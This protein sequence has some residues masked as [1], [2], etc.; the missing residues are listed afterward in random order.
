MDQSTAKEFLELAETVSLLG[1]WELNLKTNKLTWSDGVFRICGYQPNAFEVT[2]ESGLSIIHPEDRAFAIEKMT[3]AIEKG[4]PYEIVKRFIT[5][6][7][8]II[9]ILSKA[10]V[11]MDEN[12]NPDKLFGVF[13]DI[14][15]RVQLENEYKTALKELKSRNQF[16]ETIIEHLPI[17]IAVNKISTGEATIVNPS[18]SNIYGWNNEDFINIESFFKK[19]YPDESYRTK[20]TNRIYA[21]IQSGNPARMS[22]ENIKITTSKNTQRVINAK[23]I[24]LFNQDLMIST[25]TDITESVNSNKKY[26]YLFK[27]NP[28]IMLVFDLNTLEIVDCNDVALQK[29]GYSRTEF[30][31]KTIKNIRPVEDIGLLDGIFTDDETYLKFIEKPLRHQSKSGNVFYV[32]ISAR[33]INYENRK[34]S[35][36]QL[37][38]ITEKLL[39]EKILKESENKYKYLFE[40]NPLPMFIWDFETRDIVD[41]N[42]EALNL[43]NYTREEFLKLNIL[44]I[45]IKEDIKLLEQAIKNEYT[46]GKIHKSIWRHKKRNGELFYV[47]VTGHLINYNGRKSSLVMLN[48][49]TKQQEYELAIIES[50]QRF[51]YATKATSDAIWDWD[52]VKENVYWGD[53]FYMLFGYSKKDEQNNIE[54]WTKNIHPDDLEKLEENLYKS[55]NSDEVK[56]TFE[57]RFRKANGDYAFVIDKCFIIRDKEGKAIRIVGAINDI[58]K[59]KIEVQRLKLLESVITHTTDAVLITEAEPFELPGPRIIYVNEAFT[60]MTGY[61]ADE[62]IGKTPRILQGPLSD[63]SELKRLSIALSKWETCEIT[64]INYKKNGEPFWIDFS[65][66]PVANETGWYTHWIAIERDVTEQKKAEAELKKALLEKNEILESI[67]DGFFAINQNWVVTYWN[68]QAEEMLGFSKKQIL[69]KYIWNVFSDRID[70]ETYIK[71]HQ[72]MEEQSLVRFEDYFEDT[73]KWYEISIYPSNAGLSV[74]LKDISERVNYTKAIEDKNTKL[75]EIAYTQ[76]HIVR[77]PLARILGLTKLIKDLELNTKNNGD[78]LLNYLTISANELDDV[79]KQIVSKT[80]DI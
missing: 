71:Y 9:H 44:D 73:N 34:C 26:E 15:S 3:E 42:I 17:G 53:G 32:S 33:I 74:Y 10:V 78:D 70:S 20:M 49:I 46:Y 50:N 30:L 76:S 14:T 23:N 36:V 28:A 43:Y 7:K 25:V 60:K 21:D 55:I 1:T 64:T 58:S 59:K 61:S 29:Y 80:E 38:D 48:D 45:R 2:F 54:F 51:E 68:P 77:A 22:W 79:I 67:G 18:F 75:R 69:G 65:V 6:D 8:K 12:N 47:D 11:I 57:Y 72:A 40:N 56:F 35:L 39:T 19:I 41:C 66:I 52:L 16:I 27:N 37:T 31:S 63:K 5:K 24:P 62:V 13:Q 4:T